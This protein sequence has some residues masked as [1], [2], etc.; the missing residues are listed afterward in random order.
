MNNIEINILKIFSG[1]YIFSFIFH[2]ISTYEYIRISEYI[3]IFYISYFIFLLIKKKVI[4]NFYR[5]DLFLLLMPT[6]AFI[7]FFFSNFNLSFLIGSISLFYFFL[8]YYL[9]RNSIENIGLKIF[10]KTII[11][12]AL[13]SSLLG[14][15]GWVLSQFNIN[16]ILSINSPYPL[17]I[18]KVSRASALLT[19]PS[20]LAITNIISI[21]IILIFYSNKRNFIFYLVLIIISFGLLLTFSKS[22][23]LFLAFLLLIFYNKKN[24]PLLNYII[25]VSVFSLIIFHSIFTSFLFINKNNNNKWLNEN[26]T[27]LF[28]NPIYENFF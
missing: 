19:T 22:I 9:I 16:N 18:G 24:K 26:F 21:Y 3:F 7:L 1:I 20:L 23:V 10:L 28:L 17:S 12:I 13:V 4:L 2:N 25:F 14:I 6:L 15:I 27:P 11:L 5:I 8:I